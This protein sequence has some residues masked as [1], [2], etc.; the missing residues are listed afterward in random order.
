MMESIDASCKLII[1]G[2][3]DFT[4]DDECFR[5]KLAE[6][7]PAPDQALVE[8]EY[9][10][11]GQAREMLDLAAAK[12]VLLLDEGRHNFELENG[13]L[14]KIFASPYTVS[15]GQWAFEISP[16]HD[17]EQMW[18]VGDADVVMTHS[19]REGIF[20]FAGPGRIG[21]EGLFR[22][23]ARL[24]PLMH[25]F[26]HCHRGWAAKLTAWHDVDVVG[27]LEAS[28]FNSINNDESVM[29][30]SLATLMPRNFDGRE[31]LAD[32]ERRLELHRSRGC[33]ISR[34]GACD[35][36]PLRRG[37]HTLFVNAAVMG[38]GD[39]DFYLPWMVELDLPAAAYASEG[40]SDFTR[41][42]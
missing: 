27:G 20:D 23:V 4:L 13:A 2:N 6:V 26:G 41:K 37:E 19:P 33:R 15:N 17:G 39:D 8:R 35:I 38:A 34:H 36:E 5:K 28:H 9:G 3:H 10:R 31:P 30:E 14:L 32:K 16:F 22:A 7:N 25:C 1:A 11:F 21:S 42:H 18:S 29:I 40:A 12:G 24:R